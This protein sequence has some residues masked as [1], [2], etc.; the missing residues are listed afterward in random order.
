MANAPTAEFP[1]QATTLRAFLCLETFISVFDDDMRTR[2]LLIRTYVEKPVVLFVVAGQS[3]AVGYAR[4]AYEAAKYCGSCWY[5]YNSAR[6]LRPL[7]DP[8]SGLLSAY[9]N[10]GSA[11]PSLARTFFEITGRKVALLNV[12]RGGSAVTSPFSN[13]WYGEDDENT[14]RVNASTQFNAMTT[15]LG[16]ANDDY[17]LGGLLWIQGEAETSGLVAENV[18]VSEYKSGTLDVFRFFRELTSTPNLPIFMSQI[19]Y[20]STVK[21]NP[22]LLDAFHQIQAA[23]T[24]LARDNANVFMAFEGAKYFLDAGEMTDNIH[25]SQNGYNVVGKAFARCAANTL[26]F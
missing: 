11:W 1:G 14:L 24:E 20:Q 26:T 17:V 12:A 2:N 21:T 22:D 4:P 19:G 18:T 8:T 3:N 13:T 16:T 10:F 15:A 23:Q 9:Q 7:K 5:W 25:Y 6:E